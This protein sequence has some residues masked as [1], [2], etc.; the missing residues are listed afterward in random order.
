MATKRDDIALRINVRDSQGN[1]LGGTVDILLK[2]TRLRSERRQ[3]KDV[4]ASQEITISGLRRK[5]EG[6][7]EVIVTPSARLS[8]P[9]QQGKFVEIPPKGFATLEFVFDLEGKADEGDRITLRKRQIIRGQLVSAE[10]RRPL[11]GFRIEAWKKEGRPRQPLGSAQSDTSGH[12]GIA[13]DERYFELPAARRPLVSFRVLLGDDEL[14]ETSQLPVWDPRHPNHPVLIALPPEAVHRGESQRGAF[15]IE[16]R[17]TDER[18][19]AVPGVRVEVMD[20]GLKVETALGEAVTDARG[21]YRVAY[22]PAVLQDKALADIVVR[23]SDP[24]AEQ[25]AVLGRSP[26]RYRAGAR[27]TMDLTIRSE[28]VPKAT[29]YERL[30]DAVAPHLGDSELGDLSPEGV[31][32]VANKSGWDARSVAMAARAVAVSRQTEIPPA[33]YY[34]LFRAGAAGDEE[35]AGRL[36]TRTLEKTLRASVEA[37]LIPGEDSIEESVERHRELGVATL[38]GWRSEGSVSSLGEML[39]LTLGGQDRERFLRVYQE[40][41]DSPEA[42]WESLAQEGFTEDEVARLQT[43]AKLGSMTLQNRTVVARL[44]ESSELQE[45]ADLVRMGLYDSR[46]WLELIGDDVP[47]GLTP[48][49]YAEG[50]AAQV[51]LSYP[52]TVTSELVRRDEIPLGSPELR[53]EVA[54]FIASGDAETT[55]GVDPIKTW[56]GYDQLSAEGRNAVRTVERLYQMSPSNGS[57]L[58]LAR[59]GL[60][61]AYQVTGYS[62]EGFLTAFGG[63]FPSEAE[64]RMIYKK[65][66]EIHAS[67]LNVVTSYLTQRAAPNVYALTGLRERTPA[68]APPEVPGAPTLEELFT[69][70]DYC[71]CEHCKSVLSPAAY[72]VELLQFLDLTGVPHDKR[73]PI[74]VLLERRPDLEHILLT[75]ENT[76]VALPYVD[77]V[78]EILEHYVV[79]GNLDSFSGFNMREGSSSADLLADPEFVTGTAYDQTRAKVYPWS[80]PFDMPLQALRLLLS[81]MDLSLADA[82]GVF[83]TPADARR[84]AVGLSLDEYAILTDTAFRNLPEYFG[85]PAGA[86]ISALNDAVADA[87]TFARRTA[88]SHEELVALLKTRFINP[89]VELVPALRSLPLSL[90]TLQSWFD[91][92]TSDEDLLALLP[93]GFDLTAFGGDVLQWL[94]DNRQLIMGMIVLTDVSPE[95]VECDFA[96]VELRL[97]LP[98][99]AAN[100]LTALQYHKLLRFIRLWKKLGWSL[101]ETDELLST[102]LDVSSEDLTLGNIDGAFT[103]LL[104][105]VGNFLRLASRLSLSK[106]KQLA[107]LKVWSP[108]DAPAA[109]RETLAGLLRMG[110]VD[111]EDL[112]EMSGADPLADDLDAD[113]PSVLVFVDLRGRLKELGLKVTDLNYLLRH[114]DE[115]GDLTPADDALLRDVKAL[116]DALSAVETQLSTSP[117]TLDLAYAQSRMALVYDTPVGERFF[118]LLDGS[119]IYRAPFVMA[120]E[121]LPQKLADVTPALGYDPFLQELTFVGVLSAATHGALDAAADSLTLADV[122]QIVDQPALDGLIDDFKT[123]TQALFDAG[124]ADL[125]A[126]QDDYPELKAAYDAVVV[127]PAPEAQAAALLEALLPELRHQLKETALRTSLVKLLGA[128][129]EMVDALLAATKSDGDP[130]QPVL[131]DLF[132]LEIPVAF[133]ADG[134]HPFYLDPPSQDDYILYVGAPEGTTVSLTLAGETVIPATAM[135]PSGEVRSN[136]DITLEV[137]VPAP[138]E[139]TLADLPGGEAAELLWRSRGM[140]RQPVPATRLYGSAPVAEA[141]ASLLRLQKAT[142]L[143]KLLALTPRELSHLAV[144]N[145]STAGFLDELAVAGGLAGAALESLWAKVAWLAWFV[146]WKRRSEPEEDTWVRILEEPELLTPQGDPLLARASDWRPEI[147]DA[148]LTAFGLAL[149]DLSSLPSLRRVVDAMRLLGEAL[150]PAPDL[151]DWSSAVP[152]AAQV[153]SAKESLRQRLDDAPWR[154]LLQEVN[155]ELRN[156]RLAALVSYVIHHQPPAAGVDTPERLYEHLL[157]D[158]QM[159]ACRQTSRI[160]QALSSIQLFITRCLMNLEPEVAAASI[161]EDHWQWMK[162]YRVWEANRKVFLYPENWLEPELRDGKSPFFRE[163]EAELLKSD[164]TQELAEDAYYGYLKKLDEVA[165]LDIVAIYLEERTP[166]NQDDDVLHVIGRTNGVTREHYYRRFE[167]GYWTPWEKVTLNI[168]GDLVVPV[169]WKSRLFLFWVTVLEKGDPGNTSAKPQELGNKPWTVTAD[170]TIEIS[171]GWGEYF[172]G[173]WT[174]PKSTEMASPLLISGVWTF[175][176]G[177]LQISARTHKPAALSERLILAVTYWGTGDSYVL[178]FTSKNSPPIIES[179][180]DDV[181]QDD[182]QS[183]TYELF[184]PNY[185]WFPYQNELRIFS[186][187]ELVVA[188]RQPSMAKKPWIEETLLEKSDAM[189][190]SF[191]IRPLWHPV[192][193]Q[194]EAPFFYSDEQAVFFVQGDERR[195][196]DLK[197]KN[198]GYYQWDPDLESK[199]RIPQVKEYP[200][201]PKGPD[202]PLGPWINP[203]E[204]VMSQ[205]PSNTRVSLAGEIEFGFGGARFGREGILAAIQGRD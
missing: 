130:G 147:L 195:S 102:F 45:P 44:L 66:Q 64:A 35:S 132:A 161:R 15:E 126:L 192:R 123:A 55:I 189:H 41:G 201:V 62:E 205:V 140:A 155:D 76:N 46:A 177:L 72:M 163:L 182:V 3:L 129:A 77:I 16:G 58:T 8:R 4:D 63:E 202:D 200:E 21:R 171:L 89:G 180:A 93:E 19:V 12:F 13:L 198:P 184:S 52:S 32:H 131:R 101:Q 95:P 88:V 36:S 49:A 94:E 197:R 159:D 34:A 38:S 6:K 20:L 151:V 40:H 73:N 23:V 79:N 173:K 82:W 115:T 50:L 169:V 5:P 187:D 100:R 7:Y 90:K 145:A 148:V 111:L 158:V 22:D 47:E 31:E 137:G 136:V 59:E 172:K 203:G 65:A 42:L 83:R 121:A 26:V 133:D 43:H 144:D 39:D 2:H 128:E 99:V 110:I 75:C 160:R 98:D 135:G 48:E 186:E 117:E 141:R 85:E 176:P 150:Y 196:Y 106:R 80:L 164:L 56:D 60:H 185:F 138:A 87:K 81:A 134:S 18:G 78:N 118:G 105:R 51:S 57:M 199:I 162:R 156:R 70:L 61:S 14:V 142:A 114:Q 188:L 28:D 157:V 191:R 146:E 53:T 37:G 25:G 143:V 170:K 120:E 153:A 125:Q 166:S 17:V 179:G 67:T 108:N 29:E 167:Y 139:L 86:S 109:R 84:E 181:L 204:P 122:E 107:W 11:V 54:D 104:A 24:E 116:R 9:G 103:R 124:T 27:E 190:D 183:F 1:F 168:E 113:E 127:L 30:L 174:S 194:W 74:E 71:A 193:N 178:T 69:N 154:K 68:A 92:E 96:Q 175:W 119:S 152:D 10:D 91:G 112:A 165:R 33:H 149:A 97:A